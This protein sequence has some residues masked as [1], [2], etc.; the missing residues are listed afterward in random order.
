MYINSL[1]FSWITGIM[2]GLEFLFE[3]E[4]EDMDIDN[5]K[6]KFGIAIDLGIVRI[7][8]QRFK[9]TKPE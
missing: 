5:A 6:F 1:G 2:F 4:A 9:V 3:D 8:Y 7:L